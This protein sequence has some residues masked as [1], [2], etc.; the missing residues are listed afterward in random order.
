MLMLCG[1][2]LQACISGPRHR[3]TPDGFVV[4]LHMCGAEVSARSLFLFG[5]IMQRKR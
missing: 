3:C 5:D 4:L 1:A 2:L